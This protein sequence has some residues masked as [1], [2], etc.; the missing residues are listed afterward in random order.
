MRS[1]VRRG[2]GLGP[3][4]RARWGVRV[5]LFAPGRPVVR[6][7]R[8]GHKT[9][10]DPIGVIGA[11]NLASMQCLVIMHAMRRLVF[12][13]LIV[14]LALRSWT[15]DAMAMQMALGG[16]APAELAH[17]QAGM[18]HADDR[19]LQAHGDQAHS[20][21]PAAHHHADCSDHGAGTAPDQAAHCQTCSFCQAC[22]S[23]AIAW[24]PPN[25]AG[26]DATA[27]LPRMG[28]QRFASAERT[29]WLK[30]PIS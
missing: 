10:P 20:A 15:G 18:R 2:M 21:A 3:G 16:G 29:A 11:A 28:I 4:S 19:G 9:R 13:M 26:M 12:T 8:R 6:I 25:L 17:A 14:L 22:H 30:P 7:Q 23:V 5:S 1:L 27:V 24:L